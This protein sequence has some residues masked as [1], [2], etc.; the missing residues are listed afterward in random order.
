MIDRNP[1][2]NGFDIFQNY[3]DSLLN[4]IDLDDRV[5]M[6]EYLLERLYET[7]FIWLENIPLDHNRAVD[8]CE[9]RSDYIRRIKSSG[10]FGKTF[11]QDDIDIFKQVMNEKPCSLL[12]MLVAFAKRLSL[13]MDFSAP[14]WFWMFIDNLGIGWAVNG[15]FDIDIVDSVLSDFM[16][17]KCSVVGGNP[18][19]LFPCDEVYQ[20]L[21]KDLYY[22]ANLFIGRYFM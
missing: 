6:Y 4:E 14:N 17:G 21:D 3:Y 15:E 18:P 7:E 1:N 16:Y 2:S 5:L 10:G 11:G 8:G 13:I 22:Q 19:V 20:N 12:E 9:L